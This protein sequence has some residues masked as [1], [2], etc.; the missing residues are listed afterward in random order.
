MEDIA[1]LLQVGTRLAKRGEYQAAA[2]KF[3]EAVEFATEDPRG[4]FGLGVCCARAGG[5]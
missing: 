2:E 4:W 5:G 3:L 1:H